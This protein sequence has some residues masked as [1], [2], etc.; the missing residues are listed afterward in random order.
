MKISNMKLFQKIATSIFIFF[1]GL[2]VLVTIVAHA[3]RS[4]STGIDMG[5]VQ[6]IRYQENLKKLEKK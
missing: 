1:M 6:I 3:R 4:G 5:K 2:M